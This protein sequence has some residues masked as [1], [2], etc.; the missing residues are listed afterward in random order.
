MQMGEGIIHAQNNFG[1]VG[2]WKLDALP[3]AMLLLI[4]AHYRLKVKLP[5]AEPEAY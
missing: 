4:N 2:G 3:N 5:P 1:G